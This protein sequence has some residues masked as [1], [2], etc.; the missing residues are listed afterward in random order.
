MLKIKKMKPNKLK[1]VL[2]FI[3]RTL[4]I[5]SIYFPVKT[6]IKG[7]YGIELRINRIDIGLLIYCITIIVYM[8][9]AII[10]ESLFYKQDAMPF[11][12]SLVCVSFIMH[13]MV[14]I[15][16]TC[17]I[18][19]AFFS[20]IGFAVIIMLLFSVMNNIVK[21]YI[22]TGEIENENFLPHLWE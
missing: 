13:I 3:A 12:K 20:D 22:I 1:F 14:F 10:H 17:D 9:I 6:F 21:D 11:L 15:R 19:V 5:L 18:A 16:E 8:M 2:R 4:M 7:R